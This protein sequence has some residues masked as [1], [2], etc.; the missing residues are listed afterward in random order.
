MQWGSD[1]RA[2]EQ[3]LKDVTV[4]DAIESVLSSVEA[5]L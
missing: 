5:P 1:F 3:V 2:V 4:A